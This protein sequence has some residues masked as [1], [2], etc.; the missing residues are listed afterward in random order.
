MKI[1]HYVALSSLVLLLVAGGEALALYRGWQQLAQTEQ[2]QRQHEAL[3]QQ[4]TV[5]LQNSLRDYLA[6]GDP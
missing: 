3:Q 4:V 5:A 6:A 1:A 2:T